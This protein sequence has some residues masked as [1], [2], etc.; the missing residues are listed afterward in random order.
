MNAARRVM[1]G[2]ATLKRPAVERF[3]RDSFDRDHV[4]HIA[5]AAPKSQPQQQPFRGVALTAGAVVPATSTG[6]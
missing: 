6:V 4:G 5:P 2:A 1:S 3:G